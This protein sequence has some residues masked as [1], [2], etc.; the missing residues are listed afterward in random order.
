[1]HVSTLWTWYSMPHIGRQYRFGAFVVAVI[2]LCHSATRA[3]LPAYNP[4]ESLECCVADSDI[5]LVGR[6]TRS[7]SYPQAPSSR[8]I[9][10][11]EIVTMRVSEVLKGEVPGEVSFLAFGWDGSWWKKD[12]ADILVC[13]VKGVRFAK[14]DPTFAAFPLALRPAPWLYNDTRLAA[15]PLDGSVAAISKADF[16]VL[17]TSDEILAL[18]RKIAAEPSPGLFEEIPI[19]EDRDVSG[20]RGLSTKSHGNRVQVPVDAE[21]ERNAM[22]L[23]G[24]RDSRDRCYAAI[25]LKHFRSPENERLLRAMLNDPTTRDSYDG[26]IFRGR[27]YPV[28]W[29]AVK[30]LEEWGVSF[31]KPAVEEWFYWEGCKFMAMS[32]GPYLLA[33]AGC[34][35]ALVIGI[36]VRRRRQRDHLGLCAV[37]GYDLRATPHRCP[38]CGTIPEQR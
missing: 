11:W 1:M 33:L 12:A 18:A 5:V 27:W 15:Y 3:A 8:M 13:L 4:A 37:C 10:G 21:L 29:W 35:A 14:S 9:Y 16:T 32:F 34:V 25:C 20:V 7:I 31:E 36:R 26:A 30:S 38:E 6:V 23:A 17:R 28:R 19:P 2:L 22:R 24:S